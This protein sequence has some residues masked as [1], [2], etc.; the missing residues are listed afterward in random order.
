[1]IKLGP[2]IIEEKQ[3]ECKLAIPKEQ[4][5]IQQ[6]EYV[7]NLQT[8]GSI[9]NLSD[10]FETSESLHQLSINIRKVFVGGLHPN[11]LET[12]LKLYFEQFGLIDQCVIMTDKF[13]GKSRGIFIFYI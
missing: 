9:P 12:Q 13:S 10:Q 3:V 6:Q 4:I 1:V 11:L 5:N 7:K 8:I 2:H